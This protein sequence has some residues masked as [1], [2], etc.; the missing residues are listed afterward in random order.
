M[1]DRY[2][3]LIENAVRRERARTS[4]YFQDE[5]VQKAMTALVKEL[6]RVDAKIDDHIRAGDKASDFENALRVVQNR[7]IDKHRKNIGQPMVTAFPRREATAES[8]NACLRMLSKSPEQMRRYVWQLETCGTQALETET[9]YIGVSSADERFDIVEQF[10]EYVEAKGFE[11]ADVRELKVER[12]ITINAARRMQK[13]CKSVD[14]PIAFEVAHNMLFWEHGTGYISNVEAAFLTRVLS[15]HVKAA[16]G[17]Y[18][19]CE[20]VND[21]R[22]GVVYPNA[23]KA[24]LKAAFPLYVY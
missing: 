10:D 11:L 18:V 9:P 12:L 7:S 5:G 15:G 3:K 19:P 1:N 6:G 4:M 20:T 13:W 17:V 22:S 16:L 14:I 2:K 24:A 23:S 8:E 21:I